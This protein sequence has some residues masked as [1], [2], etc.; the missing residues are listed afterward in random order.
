MTNPRLQPWE[1]TFT[2]FPLSS[3]TTRTE[4]GLTHP[5]AHRNVYGYRGEQ[6]DDDLNAYYLRARYYQPGIGRFLTTDS[7]ERFTSSPISLH[8][9]VYGNASP[10]NY[11]DPSGE[12]SL[13]DLTVTQ[14]ILGN[15][16]A[17]G[18]GMI[19]EPY[20]GVYSGLG[21]WFFLRGLQ[22]LFH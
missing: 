17:I 12:T 20:L 8:R 7:E 6:Y 4:I 3:P 14:V 2:R 1:T 15:V 19:F 18:I 22:E 10:V 5:A 21:K 13:M 16:A 11:S 9:Y